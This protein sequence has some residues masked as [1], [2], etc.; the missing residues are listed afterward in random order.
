MQKVCDN[1]KTVNMMLLAIAL[2]ALVIIFFLLLGNRFFSRP[3]KIASVDTERVMGEHPAF[4][5]AMEKF[6]KET[7][8]AQE[9]LSKLEGEK[10]NKE[11]Q[12]IFMQLQSLAAKLQ[13]EAVAQVRDDI[14]KISKKKGYS[15]VLDSKSI[16]VG[17]TNITG[18]I[19]SEMKLADK[20]E[21]E[22]ALLPMIPVK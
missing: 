19:L 21:E 18:E 13:E 6:Q 4:K 16:V 5:E 15:Y 2:L 17:G 20:V 3:I 10:K 8:I 14:Q 7:Q 22:T 1:K 12:E 9:R 11:Q